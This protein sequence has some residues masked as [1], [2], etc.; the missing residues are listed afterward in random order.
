MRGDGDQWAA[1]DSQYERLVDTSMPLP[2]IQ[3]PAGQ[4]KR[5]HRRIGFTTRTEPA[6]RDRRRRSGV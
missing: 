5:R 2:V 4:A 1:L 6:R 3:D